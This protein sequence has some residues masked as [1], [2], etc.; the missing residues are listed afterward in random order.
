MV[1]FLFKKSIFHQFISFLSEMDF[2][3]KIDYI[4]LAPAQLHL[5][6][7]LSLP[8]IYH[9]EK[10]HHNDIMWNDR[11]VCFQCWGKYSS[12]KLLKDWLEDFIASVRKI[13]KDLINTGKWPLFF[14]MA[15]RISLSQIKEDCMHES[16]SLS[17]FN[18]LWG[19][20]WRACSIYQF[21]AQTRW[22][23]WNWKF[24]HK[25]WFGC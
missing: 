4:S 11:K 23:K 6:F 2:L 1:T 9:R 3:A 20:D 22:R 16:L 7:K 13:S 14:M 5:Q 21:S 25:S 10:N 8:L 19:V 17:N 12:K 15:T 24:C 18:H